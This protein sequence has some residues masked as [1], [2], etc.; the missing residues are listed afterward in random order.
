MKKFKL[1]NIIKKS[2]KELI[3][4][5][6]GRISSFQGNTFT[7]TGRKNQEEVPESSVPN[8][9]KNVQFQICDVNDN[10][11]S[12]LP[13]QPGNIFNG[14]V[15]GGG[16]FQCDGQMCTT[17]DIGKE[18]EDM[19]SLIAPGGSPVIIFQGQT[20]SYIKF[21]LYGFSNPT[22]GDAANITNMVSGYWC[23]PPGVGYVR[24]ACCGPDGLP[25]N[26][27]LAVPSTVGCTGAENTYY[28]AQGL[29][30]TNCALSPFSGGPGPKCKK[31]KKQP[32]SDPDMPLFDRFQKLANIRK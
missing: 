19:S 16:G 6:V 24:C 18:Y 12:Y 10:T 9:H 32:I 7:I 23:E 17:Q 22:I 25:Q 29:N 3:N 13:F 26:M 15:V 14:S 11:P 5:Q 1:K 20:F 31:I 27:A 30:V 8:C 21:K 4:E 2:I 28:A